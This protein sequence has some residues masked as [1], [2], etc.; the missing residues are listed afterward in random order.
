MQTEIR[1]HHVALTDSFRRQIEARLRTAFDRF[2]HNVER[3][4][5]RFADV[6]GPRG[7]VDKRCQVALELRPGG[8]VRVEADADGVEAAMSEAVARASTALARHQRR[9]GRP[10][11]LPPGFE[12]GPA[13]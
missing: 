13:T 9:M 2:A 12:F 6:N 7:G 10:S 3:I 1:S 8:H 5:V 4:S 11:R